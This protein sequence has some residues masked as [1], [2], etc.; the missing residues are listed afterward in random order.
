MEK[1]NKS[2]N[3]TSGEYKIWWDDKN[4]V[5]RVYVTGELHEA[6]TYEIREQAKQFIE[7]RGG[8]MDWLVIVENFTYPMTASS[9]ERK[10]IAEAIK[11]LAVGKIAMVG[12][13]GAIKALLT[14]ILKA[15]GHNN[16]KF[17]KTEE[18]A[19][20]WLKED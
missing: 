16:I 19:L 2:K 6:L 17:F 13:S 4:K 11:F 14:F 9:R 7:E 12:I 3:K 5:A 10:G 18:E 15:A 1:E 20:K 8:S